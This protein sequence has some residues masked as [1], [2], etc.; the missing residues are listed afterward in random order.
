MKWPWEPVADA[1]KSLVDLGSEYIVDKDKLI[2]FQYKASKLQAGITN[3]LL[4][5]STVPWVDATIKILVA[6]NTFSRPVGGALMT[7]FAAYCVI[8]NIDID[9]AMQTVF[10]GAFPAWG[11]SRHIQKGKNSND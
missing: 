6:L 10:A 4:E 9:P 5:T 11:V 8:N 1:V 3:K 2:E 7:A